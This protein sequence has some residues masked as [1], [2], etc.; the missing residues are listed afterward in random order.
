M[1]SLERDPSSG[2]YKVRFRLHGVRYKRS[3]KTKDGKEARA[4]IVR[5]EETIRL[6]ERGRLDLPAD[7]DPAIFILSDGK[8]KAKVIAPKVRTLGEL[9]EAYRANLP[10]G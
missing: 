3:I 2:R 5:L 7:A 10:P 1:A 8:Q 9:F 6:T 4:T